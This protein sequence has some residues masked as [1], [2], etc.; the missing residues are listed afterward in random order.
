M[1]PYCMYSLSIQRTHKNNRMSYIYKLLIFRCNKIVI[2]ISVKYNLSA[3]PL[4]QEQHLEAM[5]LCLILMFKWRHHILN[6]LW[7]S[8]PFMEDW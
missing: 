8:S 4:K 2:C 7:S 6:W 3:Y 1:K 5:G